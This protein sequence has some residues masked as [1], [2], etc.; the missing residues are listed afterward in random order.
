MTTISSAT[1]LS[2]GEALILTR[3]LR[4]LR[5]SRRLIRAADSRGTLG[6]F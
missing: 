2:R 4:R 3:F 6:V 5:A 1:G